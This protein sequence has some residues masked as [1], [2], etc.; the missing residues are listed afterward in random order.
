MTH[1]KSVLQNVP[2]LLRL[3]AAWVL[4]LDVAAFRGNLFC[5]EGPLCVPPSWVAPPLLDL[6][7]LLGEELVLLAR[8]NGRVDHVVGSHDGQLVC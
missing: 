1:L 3:S 6:L 5:G 7:Y 4:N 8:I 2:Q